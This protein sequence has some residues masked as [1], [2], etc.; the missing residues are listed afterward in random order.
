[1]T[2]LVVKAKVHPE[3]VSCRTVG[4]R[5]KRLQNVPSDSL[6]TVSGRPKLWTLVGAEGEISGSWADFV[7]HIRQPDYE[8]IRLGRKNSKTKKWSCVSL[9]VAVWLPTIDFNV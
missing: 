1:M 8:I 3:G 6:L 7:L 2:A 9:G 5:F 4:F